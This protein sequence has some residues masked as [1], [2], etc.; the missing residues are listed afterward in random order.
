MT[1][2]VLKGVFIFAASV[3]VLSGLGLYANGADRAYGDVV[4]EGYGVIS[5]LWEEDQADE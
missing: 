4:E 1:K 3:V 5:P 2:Q